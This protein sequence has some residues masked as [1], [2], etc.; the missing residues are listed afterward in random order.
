MQIGRKLYYDTVSGEIL[1]DTGERQG[2][3]VETTLEQDV[4]TY[5]RLSER[6]SDTFDYVQLEYGQY[7]D[8][9]MRATHIKIDVATK[10]VVFDY[11][12]EVVEEIEK[13]KSL[14][15]RVTLLEGTM[16]DILLGGM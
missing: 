15:E 16:N 7:H 12:P 14:D 1:V 13:E 6:N 9:F 8:E 4:A 11:T 2:Y 5:T 10:Q 3:I